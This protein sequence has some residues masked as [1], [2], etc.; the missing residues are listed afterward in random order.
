MVSIIDCVA[1]RG[2]NSILVGPSTEVTNAEK[3]GAMETII[4]PVDA[5]PSEK[6][7]GDVVFLKTTNQ[8]LEWDAEAN[9]WKDYTGAL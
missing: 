6:K 1:T 5:L 8:L 3:L 2:Y 9:E 7:D 4:Q